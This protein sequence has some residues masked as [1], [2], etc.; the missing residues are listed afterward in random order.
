MDPLETHRAVVKA[1]SVAQTA[2]GRCA[3]KGVL[4]AGRV[5][6]VRHVGAGM[7]GIRVDVPVVVDHVCERGADQR[8]RIRVC[9][10]RV[11]SRGVVQSGH[12]VA[13]AV[14][15][16]RRHAV[17]RDAIAD[18]GEH[19]VIRPELGRL[20][21][22]IPAEDCRVAAQA[23]VKRRRLGLWVGK[24]IRNLVDGDQARRRSIELEAVFARRPVNGHFR[25]HLV[26]EVGH[27]EIDVAGGPRQLEVVLLGGTGLP[28]SP[29]TPTG[30]QGI[31]VLVIQPDRAAGLRRDDG[32]EPL[33]RRS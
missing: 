18:A 19:T 22:A 23:P 7:I 1:A 26:D 32:Q 16:E 31:N 25:A 13:A 6:Q 9:R 12:V 28:V 3:H 15:G 21:L 29:L 24:Q 10:K 27:A 33:P 11:V 4:A 30:R 20:D 8:R 5:V 17:D 14:N 2:V